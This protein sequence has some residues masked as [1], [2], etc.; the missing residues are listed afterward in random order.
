[1]RKINRCFFVGPLLVCAVA[2]PLSAP[3]ATPAIYDLGTLSRDSF[4]VAV[5]ASG[6]V[7]GDSYISPNTN[8]IHAFKYSGTPGVDGLMRDLGT[9]GGNDSHAYGIGTSGQ[10]VGFSYLAGN[11]LYRAYLYTGTPGIDGSMVDLGTLGGTTSAARAINSSGQ[12]VGSSATGSTTHAFLYSGIPG[13]GG[14]MIDLG[15]LNGPNGYSTA[16]AISSTG[17]VAGTSIGTF[18]GPHAVRYIGAP[19]NVT[20]DDLGT[21]GGTQSD[22]LAINSIGQVAGQSYTVGNL[23]THAFLYSGTPGSGGDMADLGTL[24]GRDSVANAVN[25]AGQVIG[26]SKIAGNITYHGF[27]YTGT[28]GTGGHMIDLDAWFDANNPIEGAK[29][30]LTSASGMNENGWITGDGIYN[31]GPGGLS[32]G[33]RAFLLDASALVVPEPAGIVMMGIG[34][35]FVLMARR[36]R[37]VAWKCVAR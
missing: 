4:G 19:G 5:N 26:Y 15:S 21:L 16:F 24:G 10:I 28:P 11:T 37:P 18:G 22:G 6:Q 32:D 17:L 20:I 12:I 3:A 33:Y 9:L 34:A 14:H 2:M 1:M 13:N 25:D 29:W 7:A 36:L 23:A 27:L 31:D 35:A 8:T 30:T